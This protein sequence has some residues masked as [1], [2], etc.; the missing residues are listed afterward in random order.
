MRAIRGAITVSENSER[1]ILDAASIL[2]RKIVEEN[3]LSEEE[4]VSVIFSATKDLNAAFPARAVR[5]LG[6]KYVPLLDVCEMDVD[7]AL[8]M[9]IRVIIFVNREAALKE[10]KHV[11]LRGAAKLRPDLLKG[12][13]K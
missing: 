1:E 12:E 8:P 5:E 3:N 6:Y 9:T 10:I 11:Y 4:I 13:E 2:F 7:G